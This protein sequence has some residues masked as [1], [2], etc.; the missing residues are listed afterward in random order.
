MMQRATALPGQQG[1]AL[2][3]R[4]SPASEQ[5]RRL[6]QGLS[7]KRRPGQSAQ[8]S[9]LEDARAAGATLQDLFALAESLRLA[10]GFFPLELRTSIRY[11]RD[12]APQYLST[13]CV[14]EGCSQSSV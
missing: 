10:L 2:C 13:L 3:S 12:A 8:A 9:G 5:P 14:L 4:P 7:G 1:E 11:D 6:R